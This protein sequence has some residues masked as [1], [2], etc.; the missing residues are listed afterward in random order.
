MEEQ[1]LAERIAGANA[2]LAL[3]G[4]FTR[5]MAAEGERLSLA[6]LAGVRLYEPGAL[7]LVAGAGTPLAEVE[8][9]LAGEGQRL[10]FEPMDHRGLLGTSGEPT[11][12]GVMAGNVSGP[13]RVVAGAARDFCLG[14]RV[15]DGGGRVLKAGGRVM[16]N[17]TGYDLPKLFCGSRGRLGAITEV[18]LKVLPVPETEVTLVGGGGVPVLAA[19]LGT[20]FEVT[21]AAV[22]GGETLLRLEGL[23]ASVAYRQGAL[24]SRLG[25]DW[26]VAAEEES[27]ALWRQVRD[28]GP[29]HG[30]AGEVW[31]VHLRPSRA[32]GLLAALGG[33]EAV[34]DWGGGLLWLRAPGEA[35]LGE[36]AKAGGHATC[37]RG[38]AARSAEAPAVAA[39]S[40]GLKARFD[41][42]GLFGSL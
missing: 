22:M 8:A 1:E 33:P 25:G 41:P 24:A 15:V 4:G 18:A 2:P 26:R 9:L 23:E 17:V 3:G 12:G 42:R 34:I 13:R 32:E 27:R 28:V 7:T 35:L 21:G 14:L 40:A 39:L 37:V 10:A 31:R 11:I 38:G 36:V 19:G 16:K 6:G 20:P 5:G 30:L 29:F